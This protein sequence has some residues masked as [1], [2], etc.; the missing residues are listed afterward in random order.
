VKPPAFHPE[1]RIEF[2]EAALYYATILPELGR[3]FHDEMNR[4]IQEAGHT[5]GVFRIIF[6]P[7]RR[8]FTREFPYG[9]I[10]VERPDD[11]WILAVMHLH[12]EPKYWQ[13]RLTPP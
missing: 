2:A 5:P 13:H 12:R 8:H 11:L 3:R 4:L 9:I 6:A 10:Y 7:A 1:A